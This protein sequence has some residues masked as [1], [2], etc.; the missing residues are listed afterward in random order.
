MFEFL[1]ST[2]ALLVKAITTYPESCFLIKTLVLLI[3]FYKCEMITKFSL[4]RPHSVT[5]GALLRNLAIKDES[6]CRVL[7]NDFV[8]HY[9]KSIG[10]LLDKLIGGAIKCTPPVAEWIFAVP[11]LHFMMKVCKPYEQLQGISLDDNS[12]TK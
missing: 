6:T 10:E 4:S 9:A 7:T 12:S 2:A 5:I 8:I 3:I 1:T 11:L